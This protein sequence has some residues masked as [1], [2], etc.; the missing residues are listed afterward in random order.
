M[1]PPALTVH[2]DH[3]LPVW[4]ER[5]SSVW[6]HFLGLCSG[7]KVCSLPLQTA[8]LSHLPQI[9]MSNYLWS[10]FWNGSPFET[11]LLLQVPNA[12]K[13]KKN[14]QRQLLCGGWDKLTHLG[15]GGGVEHQRRNPGKPKWPSQKQTM[16]RTD[17]PVNI[18]KLIDHEKNKEGKRDLGHMFTQ[19]LRK[20]AKFNTDFLSFLGLGAKVTV[21]S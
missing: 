9:I 5:R 12:V 7:E 6:R 1:C 15:T 11:Q 20:W 8:L 21:S 10:I 13:K 3:P 18:F 16:S 19:L 17:W 4:R 2:L 14:I